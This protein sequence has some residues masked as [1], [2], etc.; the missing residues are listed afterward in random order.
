VHACSADQFLS[1]FDCIV[2]PTRE[3]S[4]RLLLEV[5]DDT[6]LLGEFRLCNISLPFAYR[7][8]LN[9]FEIIYIVMIE[10]GCQVL[11]GEMSVF[12]ALFKI[13]VEMQNLPY[14]F[15][16]EEYSENAVRF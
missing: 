13:F 1:L 14:L 16:V 2:F 4:A 12:S 6:D 7:S 15:T 5:F 9:P 10:I 8:G 11:L 3:R